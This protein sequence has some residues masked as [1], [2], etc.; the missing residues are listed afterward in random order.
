LNLT[1]I[2]SM[3]ASFLANLLFMRSS[4]RI[5]DRIKKAYFKS[6]ISQE[7]GYFDIKKAALISSLSDD[8]TKVA[9][10]FGTNLMNFT[11]FGGQII[12]GIV[13]GFIASWQMT[14]L[15]CIASVRLDRHCVT[16]NNH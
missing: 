13:L 10:A 6:V 12:G 2:A 11:M 5:S 9:D 1:Y 15:G 7:I 14:L 8:V 4:Q 3:I 16:V